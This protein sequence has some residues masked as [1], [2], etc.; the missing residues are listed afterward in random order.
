MEGQRPPWTVFTLVD[1]HELDLPKEIFSFFT[2]T[3]GSAWELNS[4]LSE[5]FSPRP[6]PYTHF[7]L[8]TFYTSLCLREELCCF[9]FLCFLLTCPSGLGDFC[10]VSARGSLGE[11]CGIMWKVFPEVHSEA[12]QKAVS[13]FLHTLQGEFS[14]MWWQNLPWEKKKHP[15]KARHP[16]WKQTSYKGH[17]GLGE[18]KTRGSFLLSLKRYNGGRLWKAPYLWFLTFAK[19]K[20]CAH[21]RCFAG[22]PILCHL[23]L[24]TTWNMGMSC[25]YP[26][27]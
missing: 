6:S 26:H 5:I 22:C 25:V 12:F 19:Y 21:M 2:M 14:E 23:G 27:S 16:A 9:V 15:C 17:L 7:V 20:T 4:F 18:K 13:L 3:F 11:T 10:L 1:G 24:W 8:C